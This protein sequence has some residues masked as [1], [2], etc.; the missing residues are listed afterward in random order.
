LG[1]SLWF[2]FHNFPL[3]NMHPHAEHA[4]EAAGAQGEFWTMHDLLFENQSL[5]MLKI[6]LDM[7]QP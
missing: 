3:T 5:S 6:F 7:Q 4:A 1:D 2:A